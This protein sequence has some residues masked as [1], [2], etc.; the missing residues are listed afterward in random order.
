[1]WDRTY[2]I[3]E[4]GHSYSVSPRIISLGIPPLEGFVEMGE[5]EKTS[6][7]QELMVKRPWL[8][9]EEPPAPVVEVEYQDLI[10][11]PVPDKKQL[12]REAAL[13][14]RQT[15]MQK[16]AEKQE[17]IQRQT[18]EMR[19]FFD[20]LSNEER[21]LAESLKSQGLNENQVLNVLLAK[22]AK[23]EKKEE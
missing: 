14:R 11:E 5:E 6:Y 21:D 2:Y 19:D 7:L 23:R 15:R 16:R 4:E 12:R 17:V 13:E 9:P 22:Q 20:S 3:N 18:K 10:V 8:F 1:M